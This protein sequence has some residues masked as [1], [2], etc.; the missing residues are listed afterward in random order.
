M[1]IY[2]SLSIFFQDDVYLGDVYQD[3]ENQAAMLLYQDKDDDA[4]LMVR[5]LSDEPFRNF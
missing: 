3:E 4:L 5:P 1:L 2:F